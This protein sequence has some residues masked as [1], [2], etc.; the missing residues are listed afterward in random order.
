[1]EFLHFARITSITIFCCFDLSDLGITL[2]LRGYPGYKYFACWSK[3]SNPPC[4]QYCMTHRSQVIQSAYFVIDTQ[5]D[6]SGS[7]KTDLGPTR[8]TPPHHRKS[9]GHHIH[10]ASVP[11]TP[12]LLPGMDDT[13]G[14]MPP[15][16]PHFNRLIPSTPQPN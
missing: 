10:P 9:D 5:T 7:S 6:G 2:T 3:I 15:G 11:A 1:V 13:R 4:I 16:R 8:T 12:S 14:I